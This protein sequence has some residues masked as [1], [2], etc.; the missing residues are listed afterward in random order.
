MIKAAPSPPSRLFLLHLQAFTPILLLALAPRCVLL[1]VLYILPVV[2]IV[3]V[4]LSP[5][6]SLYPH[7]SPY[8]LSLTFLLPTTGI[9]GR[10]DSL[11]CFQRP[12]SMAPRR[13]TTPSPPSSSRELPQ[14]APSKQKQ[15]TSPRTTRAKTTRPG[16]TPPR[17]TR[18]QT[19][20]P[21]ITNE[22]A[23]AA[24]L[25]ATQPP[26]AQPPGPPPPASSA[27]NL[28]YTPQQLERFNGLSKHATE[29]HI[30]DAAD[31]IVELLKKHK[32]NYAIM[33]GFALRIRGSRRVTFDVDLAVGANMLE[34]RSALAADPR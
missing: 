17:I 14:A 7:I 8:L 30:V 19:T 10:Y 26:A 18:S 20:R 32:I 31:H 22:K 11:I 25:A 16:I 3:R 5:R 6:P 24:K 34:L 28:T 21:R 4:P 23:A 9:S 13:T 29:H 27:T 33:G 1:F 2:F 12:E 15:T